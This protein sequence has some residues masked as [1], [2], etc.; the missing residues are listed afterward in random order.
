MGLFILI[1]EA[2]LSP[3]THTLILLKALPLV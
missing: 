3:G 1:K 2:G